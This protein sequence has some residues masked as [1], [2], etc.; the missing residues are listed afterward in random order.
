M[1]RQTQFVGLLKEMFLIP[2]NLCR[3]YLGVGG[4]LLAQ[5]SGARSIAI[6]V[7]DFFPLRYAL[8]QK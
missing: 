5:W 7:V 2:T 1:Q 4:Q 3:L 8:V 6:Y